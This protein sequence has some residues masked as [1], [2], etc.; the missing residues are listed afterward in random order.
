MILEGKS[1][2][3]SYTAMN[4]GSYNDISGKISPLVQ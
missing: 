2:Y 4:P 3:Q 1:N